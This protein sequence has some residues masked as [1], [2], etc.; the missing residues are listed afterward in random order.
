MG[1]TAIAFAVAIYLPSTLLMWTPE[2][3]RAVAF[4]L[5]VYLFY[6]ISSLVRS[7]HDF[8]RRLDFEEELRQRIEAAIVKLW[9][10]ATELFASDAVDEQAHASGQGPR[11]AGGPPALPCGA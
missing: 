7:H 9:P 6:V 1:L 2:H 11:C 10:Y 4:S 5:T 8:H 3:D